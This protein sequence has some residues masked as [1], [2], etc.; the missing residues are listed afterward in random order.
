MKKAKREEQQAKKVINW[1]IWALV[2]LFV[3]LFVGY[4]VFLS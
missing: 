3:V 1:I 4:A 2:A